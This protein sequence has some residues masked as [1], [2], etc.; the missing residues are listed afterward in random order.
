METGPSE[1]KNSFRYENFNVNYKS[2]GNPGYEQRRHYHIPS[3]YVLEVY[4]KKDPQ[5]MKKLVR[6]HMESLLESVGKKS[7]IDKINFTATHEIVSVCSN[8]NASAHERFMIE[9]FLNRYSKDLAHYTSK[10]K[11]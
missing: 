3:S 7:L 11:K 4:C 9:K 5:K 1:E 8:V 6:D 2:F 10:R